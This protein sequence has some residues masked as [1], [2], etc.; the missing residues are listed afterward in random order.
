MKVLIG[1][2]SGASALCEIFGTITVWKN[3]KLSSQAAQIIVAEM[4]RADQSDANILEDPSARLLD[5]MNFK[6]NAHS[7]RLEKNFVRSAITFAMTPLLPSRTTKF[8]LWAYVLGAA[9]GLAAALL[10][11]G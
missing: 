10:A 3:Y 9:L 2:L 1:V 11:I 4:N 6:R 8:G 5:E 7:E